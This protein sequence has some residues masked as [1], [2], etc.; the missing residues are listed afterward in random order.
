MHAFLLFSKKK[1][2]QGEGD[3]LIANVRTRFGGTI[4]MD[5]GSTLFAFDCLFAIQ[6]EREAFFTR[7]PEFIFGGDILM[8]GGVANFVACTFFAIVPGHGNSIST[9]IGGS[10]LIL[11]GTATFSGCNFLTTQLFAYNL[12][13]GMHVAVLGGVLIMNGRSIYTH[14]CMHTYK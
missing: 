13:V 8:T 6:P 3:T 5:P 2:D 7:K 12:G 1:T 14:A 10:V 4:F 11:A 9:E